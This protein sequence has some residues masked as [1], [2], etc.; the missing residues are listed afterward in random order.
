MVSVNAQQQ[1]GE[2][3]ELGSLVY[4]PEGMRRLALLSIFR[5]VG[6]IPAISLSLQD[7]KGLEEAGLI[8]KEGNYHKLSHVGGAFLEQVHD[9]MDANKLTL[10]QMRKELTNSNK[11]LRE[12]VL[13]IKIDTGEIVS[14]DM[15]ALR[16]G[17]DREEAEER[18]PQLFDKLSAHMKGM[19][20]IEKGAKEQRGFRNAIKSGEIRTIQELL[21]ALGLNT[22]EWSLQ[23]IAANREAFRALM[24]EQLATG[25]LGSPRALEGALRLTKQQAERL[26]QG[27]M[28]LAENALIKRI[29][30]GEELNAWQLAKELGFEK[31]VLKA[32]SEYPSVYG[33]FKERMRGVIRKNA[34][35]DSGQ[36]AQMLGYFADG[37]PDV[38]TAEQHFPRLFELVDAP[39]TKTGEVMKVF[40]AFVN[41]NEAKVAQ[42]ADSDLRQKFES[43]KE[44]R[45]ELLNALQ[46]KDTKT[47]ADIMGEMEGLTKMLKSVKAP[48]PKV[49]KTLDDFNS[50][51]L[52]IKENVDRLKEKGVNTSF[53]DSSFLQLS[54]R[55]GYL[56]NAISVGDVDTVNELFAEVEQFAG[57]LREQLV[58]AE[59]TPQAPPAEAKAPSVV[60][61]A[62]LKMPMIYDMHVKKIARGELIKPKAKPEVEKELEEVVY[63]G[64]PDAEVPS[65]SEIVSLFED[66]LGLIEET[67]Q[68]LGD[69]TDTT[70]LR[71]AFDELKARKKELAKAVKKG[72][73]VKAKTIV[74]TLKEFGG[75]V[76][77]QRSKFL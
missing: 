2:T 66:T 35:K 64:S 3:S 30:D 69:V 53:F 62:E 58:K 73:E 31:N 56:E 50:K 14:E 54:S 51:L 19:D 26:F 32:Q 6:R 4:S 28:M 33:A 71:K 38:K 61:K 36:L 17:L 23:E 57:V 12:L 15:L 75:I 27:E 60:E 16:L 5:E 41:K 10:Q 74:N 25:V 7:S 55:R 70:E 68:E 24:K 76:E 77:W 45:Q 9:F 20:H 59:M 40:D 49:E 44:M 63:G 37:N 18:F 67:I 46:T 48:S 39:D 42:S 11:T 22:E 52:E 47:C 43:I 8:E 34:I 65:D 1:Q 13:G 21:S 72:D 29:N